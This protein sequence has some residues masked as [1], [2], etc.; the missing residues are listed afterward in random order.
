VIS[1]KT[2][3]FESFDFV[4]RR[5]AGSF[6]EPV[7]EHIAYSS[8]QVL[9]ALQAAEDASARGCWS[10]VV[11][12][13]EAA[14]AF[15]AV[16][17]TYPPAQFPLA[18]VGVFNQPD[19]SSILN[20]PQDFQASLWK[21]QIARAEYLKAVEQAR[22]Y[23]AAGHTYQANLTFPLTCEF[24]GDPWS[25]YR[26]LG[27]AQRAGYCAY[28][29]LGRYRI[30]S[31]SPELFF[32]R[33]ENRL[34]TRP[35]KG[36]MRRGRWL[37][38]D[39]ACAQILAA[40]EKNRAENLMIVDLLRNDLGRIAIPGS[41]QAPS[42]FDVEKYETLWQMTSTVTAEC[43]PEMSLTDLFQA[44]F[45]CGSITGAPKVRTMQILRELERFPR[46]IYTGAI[47][48]VRPGGDCIFNVAI[49][50]ILLDLQTGQATFGVGGGVTHD[51]TPEG[52]YD[53]CLL[54]ASFLGSRRPDFQLF[55]TLLLDDGQYFLLDRHLA[56]LRSSA[57]Y[58][59]FPWD[60]PKA[61]IALDCVREG[62]GPGAWRV[63]LLATK[64]GLIHVD[65]RRLQSEDGGRRRVGFSTDP[66]D[67]KDPLLFHKTTHRSAYEQAL[68]SRPGC[69]DVILWNERG[70][71][72]ESS[73]ANLV[74]LKDGVAWT[75]A[76][77]SGLLAGT[78][79]DELLA[80]GQIQERII[81]RDELRTADSIYLINSVRKWMQAVLID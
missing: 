69:D 16:L 64:D 39:E 9:K 1:L 24:N 43:R 32:E 25:W 14:S 10:V 37:E 20:P 8:D 72:T 74:L 26:A 7:E 3:I 61:Q 66:I 19:S 21:P 49:R 50:T 2:A 81:H 6:T 45:P 75:P 18:W 28:L 12:A 15:D 54:K 27:T 17:T 53:E 5:W 59:G 56:R 67:A 62:C 77:S 58:F 23:I 13:Y 46:Q 60:E 79:R 11:V 34:I 38:E 80:Q 48:V 40:S 42:L 31:L 22:D 78:F 51:S 57:R 47:G 33:R 41:V 63:R 4:S 44:L 52:E 73:M 65:P 68:N 35:M 70:E 71:V 30:L 29:D 76:R 55:E 36:T